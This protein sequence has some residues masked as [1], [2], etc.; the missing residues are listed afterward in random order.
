MSKGTWQGITEEEDTYDG[1]LQLL[2]GIRSLCGRNQKTLVERELASAPLQ[3]QI[4]LDD[5]L[6][7]PRREVYLAFICTDQFL[8]SMYWGSG[9]LPR[10]EG[11]VSIAS[12]GANIFCRHRE[13]QHRVLRFVSWLSNASGFKSYDAQGSSRPLAIGTRAGPS[14]YLVCCTKIDTIPSDIQTRFAKS[15]ARPIRTYSIVSV[16]PCTHSHVVRVRSDFSP[17]LAPCRSE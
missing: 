17:L 11:H 15:N 13:S 6:A 9:G 10:I 4:A 7:E 8:G 2:G 1:K 14:P 5:I 12:L 16:L 3:E